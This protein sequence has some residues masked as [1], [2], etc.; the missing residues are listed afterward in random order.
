MEIAHLVLLRAL[1]PASSAALSGRSSSG[2]CV[3]GDRF[4]DP[5]PMAGVQLVPAAFELQEPCA[6]YGLAKRYTVP[7]R[8]NGV[9]SAV[10]HKQWGA[11][12]AE[13]ALPRRANLE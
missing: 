11:Q 6:R 1:R 13:P 2:F 10:D 9:G 4:D 7:Y 12:F 8:E 3:F 5:V